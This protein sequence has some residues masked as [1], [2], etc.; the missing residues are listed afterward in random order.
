MKTRTKLKF[1]CVLLAGTF[2]SI[3][4]QAQQRNDVRDAA[5]FGMYSQYTEIKGSPFLFKNWASGNVKTLDKAEKKNVQLKYDEVDD[6]LLLKGNGEEDMLTF[7]SPV[8]EFT[9]ADSENNGAFRTF[10]SGFAATKISTEKTLFEVLVDG[11]VKFLRKNHKVISEGKEYGSAAIV[12]TVVDGLKYYLVTANNEPTLVKL[13]QKSILALL[14][15]KQAELT[16]YIK[17]NK[18][19]LKKQEDA[20]KLVTY[21]NTL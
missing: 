2:I 8:V 17:T 5:G 21:Y 16:E 18:L 12:K 19:N 10:K 6:R 7:S 4:L 1:A 20:V 9:I 14:P 3:N 11:K 13:D 15:N